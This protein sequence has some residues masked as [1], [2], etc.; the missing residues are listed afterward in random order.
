MSPLRT[1]SKE[2]DAVCADTG[3]QALARAAAEELA[4][5]GRV[6]DYLGAEGEG[7]RLVSHL[8]AC[9]DPAYQGWRWTVTVSRASRSKTVTISECLLLPGPDAV[10]AP[11]W[12]PWRE[13]LR[14]GDLGVGDILPAAADDER[15]VP[16][17][18]LE[19][20]D[21]IEDWGEAGWAAAGLKPYSAADGEDEDGGAGE[22]GAAEGGT[23]AGEAAAG[24]GA[25]GQAGQG[26]QPPAGGA[27]RDRP[28]GRRRSR[29]T[30]AGEPAA[31]WDTAPGRVRVLS[32]IGRDDAAFRW[33]TAE[34]GPQSPLANA[35]PGPCV[36]CGF[37]IHL[38][39]PLGRVFGVC[40]N[41][42]A[43][44]DGRVVSL[45]HGCGAH[46]E[47]PLLP[48]MESPVP[49]V[50]DELGYDLVDVPGVSVDDT[51]FEPID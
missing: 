23:S 38:A 32:A 1:R 26:G 36:S 22:A 24:A 46:S 6:G 41:E 25:G 37:F 34:H 44:D 7:E 45:D 10:L 4:G 5:A 35:A 12:V 11:P 13:R 8:F 29:R 31:S 49:P 21:G 42:Y 20:D 30:A 19:G 51:D 2:P 18:A 28:G 43:P 14:P 3:A 40:A 33:Y 9:L 17:A 15:L 39:G 16:V 27:G 48:G 47:G 50:I